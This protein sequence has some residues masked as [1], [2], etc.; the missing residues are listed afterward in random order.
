[1]AAQYFYVQLKSSQ[2]AHAL[3]YLKDRGLS[4]RRSIRLDWIFQQIQQRSVSIFE[5]QGVIVMSLIVKA[6]L[7]TG[8]ALWSIG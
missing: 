7:V 4:M 8:R 1:M 6:G 2:G 5:E 3:S